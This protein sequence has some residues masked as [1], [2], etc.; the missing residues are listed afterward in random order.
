MGPPVFEATAAI[1]ASDIG[2]NLPALG[3]AGLA[4]PSS[5]NTA[6]SSMPQILAAR[7]HMMVIASRAALMVASPTA[8]VTRL[9]SVT[10]FWPSAL[11]SAM[12]VRT[13]S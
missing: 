3:P 2:G 5:Q 9:P 1:S 7:P 10:S 8:K 6:S 4:W 12:V 11:V 13:R